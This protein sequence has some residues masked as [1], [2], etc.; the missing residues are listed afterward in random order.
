M[1]D[2]IKKQLKM[3]ALLASESAD[4]MQ[5]YKYY[6][7]LLDM[8]KYGIMTDELR[9][10]MTK[11]TDIQLTECALNTLNTH[12][13]D[14]KDEIVEVPIIID[15]IDDFSIYDVNAENVFEV[16][17]TPE[18]TI[19]TYYRC[20]MMD[21]KFDKEVSGLIRGASLSVQHA[22]IPN[23]MS[24][25]STI[26]PTKIVKNIVN[27]VIEELNRNN[28]KPTEITLRFTILVAEI[29]DTEYT[30]EFEDF[31]KNYDD[32]K[33]LLYYIYGGK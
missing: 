22:A 33:N 12:F 7:F 2:N 14:S 27:S 29:G 31:K 18:M 3:E 8:F 17:V 1:L 26:M 5:K 11:S 23:G 32:E 30:I 9:R 4:I 20:L 15:L 24:L 25:S 21:C 6:A 19:N 10:I 13:R 16:V 28:V